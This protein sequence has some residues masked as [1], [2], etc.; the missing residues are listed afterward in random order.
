MPIRRTRSRPRYEHGCPSDCG[1]T[2]GRCPQRVQ[3]NPDLGETKS[4]A[5]RRTI[6]LPD[7]LVCILKAQRAQQDADR[8]AARQ[9]WVE[10]DWVFT[11]VTGMPVNPVTDYHRWRALLKRAGVRQARLHDARHTAA[12]VLLVLG[13]PERTAMGIMGW[14]TTAMAARYQHVT[15]PIRATVARQVG[16]LLWE[17][18]KDLRNAN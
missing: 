5:G 14:S 4:D 6:G 7:E 3:S 8:A 13:V 1:R 18:E 10:G 15:D 17:Q 9:L 16:G 2:P 12:T 11:G